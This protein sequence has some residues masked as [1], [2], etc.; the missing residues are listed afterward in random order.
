MFNDMR[1]KVLSWWGGNQAS[2]NTREVLNI[3]PSGERIIASGAKGFVAGVI[4][5]GLAGSVVPGFGTIAGMIGGGIAGFSSGLLNGTM[6]EV[7][8]IGSTIEEVSDIATGTGYGYFEH[9]IR[10]WYEE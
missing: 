8:G 3:N 9:E 6:L 10:N 4:T 7:F 1:H 2:Q 5:G